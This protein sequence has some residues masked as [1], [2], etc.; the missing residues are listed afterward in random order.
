MEKGKK[1]VDDGK[2]IMIG[3]LLGAGGV[4]LMT[5][6]NSF[7]EAFLM[8]FGALSAWGGLGLIIQ[9]TVKFGLKEL[10]EE[11]EK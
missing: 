9:H 11:K 2:M 3:I 6:P 8:F 1:E 4:L 5:H 10:E 7:S